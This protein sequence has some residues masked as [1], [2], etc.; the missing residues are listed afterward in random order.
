MTWQ[1]INQVLHR[2]KSKG[3]LPDTFREKKMLVFLI[4]L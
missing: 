4:Q 1:T 2:N 3:R